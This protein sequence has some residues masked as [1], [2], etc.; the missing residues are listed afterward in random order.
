[1]VRG[2]FV[3]TKSRD[4]RTALSSPG[5]GSLC[6]T[7]ACL[8][9]AHLIIIPTVYLE[10]AEIPF[11]SRGGRGWTRARGMR[12]CAPLQPNKALLIQRLALARIHGFVRLVGRFYP[13]SR[14]ITSQDR[15]GWATHGNELLARCL[16][17]FTVAV[18]VASRE[19]SLVFER[20][21]WG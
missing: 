2:E 12:L 3:R 18:T 13:R 1:M 11:F 21:T 15:D 9:N 14:L 16:A 8:V 4:F 19:A 6:G 20:A 17:P 5:T 10:I 7:S